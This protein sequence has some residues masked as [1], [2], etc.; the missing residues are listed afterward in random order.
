VLDWGSPNTPGSG[1]QILNVLVGWNN[2]MSYATC[3]AYCV[4]WMLVVVYLCVYKRWVRRREAL[5]AL[6]D[7]EG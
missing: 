7:E 4:F 6:V 5:A 2:V 1:W 3:I